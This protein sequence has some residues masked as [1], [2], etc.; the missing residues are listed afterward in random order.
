MEISEPLMDCNFPEF[1]AGDLGRS[2]D[3]FL[4]RNLTAGAPA[5]SLADDGSKRRYSLQDSSSQFLTS[6]PRV[7]LSRMKSLQSLKPAK[8]P[9]MAEVNESPRKSSD[10]TDSSATD[11]SGGMEPPSIATR[12]VSVTTT[13]TS[14]TSGRFSPSEKSPSPVD[15]L[16]H[17]S[18]VDLDLAD[19]LK[20][21]RSYT[22]GHIS[23]RRTP[24]SPRGNIAD[25]RS[26]SMGTKTVRPGKMDSF[27]TVTSPAKTPTAAMSPQR[28][29]FFEGRAG[30]PTEFP[31]R[32]SSLSQNKDLLTLPPRHRKSSRS[33]PPPNIVIPGNVTHVTPTRSPTPLDQNN[34]KFLKDAEERSI[35]TLDDDSD[36][37]YDDSLAVPTP[38]PVRTQVATPRIVSPSTDVEQWLDTSN[39]GFSFNP[40]AK[41]ENPVSRIPIG[42][43]VLDTLRISVACFPETMLLCSS[44][45][46]ETIRSHS[47]K[48][49]YRMQDLDNGSQ[50]SLNL[51][52]G[53]PKPSVW[54]WLTTKRPQDTS[55]TK[56]QP[57]QRAYLDPPTLSTGPR[58]D[59]PDWSAIRN[60]FPNG[61]DYL[62]D[63]LYAHLLA[64]NYISSLC[65]RSVPLSPTQRPGSNQSSAQSITET[66]SKCSESTQIK[67]K[68]AKLLGLSE[69]TP[70]VM[71]RSPGVDSQKS[72][73]SLTLRN[74]PSFFAGHRENSKTFGTGASRSA[75]DH[76]KSLKELQLGLAKCIARLVGTL[77]LTSHE[78]K[79]VSVT[80]QVDIKDVDPLFIRALCE[81]VRSCEERS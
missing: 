18:W 32:R 63:A 35:L 37:D 24:A 50:L 8:S 10:T 34:G 61:T 47:R 60:V 29:Y 53:S 57:R 51:G 15:K 30:P 77:R 1:L 9:A 44:L 69:D 31:I 43:E 68:A 26:M 17:Y 55:P 59:E 73:R 81:I 4:S 75:D 72:P 45:S 38:A 2:E 39:I 12:N 74:K 80:K 36:D 70:A 48:I 16:P 6:Q 13:A 78:N 40:Q 71:P 7:A 42:S 28:P 58:L 52:D 41:N 20:S 33:P 46:I 49:K 76:D 5:P 11:S 79:A 62:C 14:V 66:A 21:E 19:A 22:M 23:S 65:P 54:K 25:S 27:S 56:L 3:V 67:P 64:Y